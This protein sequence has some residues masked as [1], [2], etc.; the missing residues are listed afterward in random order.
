METNYKITE[1]ISDSINIFLDHYNL[2]PIFLVDENTKFHCFPLLNSTEICIEIKSGEKN[3]SL[4]T[5][6]FI[7]NELLKVNANKSHCLICLGGGVIC[8]IGGFVATIYKRGLKFAF[9]PTTLLAMVDASIGGKNGVNFNH[10]KN[11][12]GTFNLPEIVFIYKDF[13]KTLPLKE[14]LN[15]KA[16]MLKIAIINNQVLFHQLESFDF[17]DAIENCI[18]EKNKIVSEDYSD[19]GKRQILNFGHTIGHAIEAY[20]LDIKNTEISHGKA[21]TKGM[22][23]ETELAFKLGYLSEN[24]YY[25]ITASINKHLVSESIEIIMNEILPYLKNDKKNNNDKIVFSLPNELGSC[26][27][28]VEL[29]ESEILSF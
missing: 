7:L 8:D 23:V 11:I 9:V 2:K 17:F 20:F 15:G 29:T 25:S 24:I 19:R 1:N 5:V 13:L 28:G 16:E 3:K 14:V 10:L 6:E 18:A 22:L 4:D 12:I 21:I 26:L 27:T